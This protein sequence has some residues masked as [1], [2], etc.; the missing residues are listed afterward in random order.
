MVVHCCNPMKATNSKARFAHK[1]FHIG[2]TAIITSHT[3]QKAPSDSNNQLNT[4]KEAGYEGKPVFHGKK[5]K[6][7]RGEKKKKQPKKTK[8][9]F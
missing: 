8:R 2:S 7:N 9:E 3:I 1:I 4:S 5:E 6:K